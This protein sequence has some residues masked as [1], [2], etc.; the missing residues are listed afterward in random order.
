MQ[1]SQGSVNFVQGG[2]QNNSWNSTIVT[3]W[4]SAIDFW[5]DTMRKVTP[6]WVTLS[7][8]MKCGSTTTSQR[9]NVRLWNGNTQPYLSKTL[10]NLDSGTRYAHTVPKI[11]VTSPHC[12]EMLLNKVRPRF[13]VN[14]E[15]NCH[16]VLCCCMIMPTPHCCLQLKYYCSYVSRSQNIH[17]KPWHRS[18]VFSSILSSKKCFHRLLFCQWP[19]DEE[20]CAYMA[21]CS[22]KITFL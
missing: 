19:W 12:C 22:V 7:R 4:T 18:I 10:W 13:G 2:F 1:I 20:D 6:F 16:K 3:V 11:T 17:H 21:C 9:E 15:D 8:V 5:A 14:T